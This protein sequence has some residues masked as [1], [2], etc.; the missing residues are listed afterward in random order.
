MSGNNANYGSSNGKTVFSMG[1]GADDTRGDMEVITANEE[2]RPGT[3]KVESGPTDVGVPHAD[4]L[5]TG[6]VAA[7]DGEEEQVLVSHAEAN[8]RIATRHQSYSGSTRREESDFLPDR[9]LAYDERW[10]ESRLRPFGVTLEQFERMVSTVATDAGTE[11]ETFEERVNARRRVL[12]ESERYPRGAHRSAAAAEA[13]S[14]ADDAQ[15]AWSEDEAAALEAA[16]EEADE[17]EPVVL[18]DD[19]DDEETIA[20][21]TAVVGKQETM[22]RLAN[23][24]QMRERADSGFEHAPWWN[25]CFDALNA[26]SADEQAAFEAAGEQLYERWEDEWT[27]VLGFE[28]SPVGLAALLADEADDEQSARD[29]AFE[30]MQELTREGN[31]RIIGGY[32][33]W[34]TDA[35]YDKKLTFEGEVVA[36]FENPSHNRQAQAGYVVDDMG[37]SAKFTIWKGH[38]EDNSPDWAFHGACDAP[39]RCRTVSKGDRVLFENFTA[40]TFNGEVVIESTRLGARKSETHILSE[41]EGPCPTGYPDVEGSVEAPPERSLSIDEDDGPKREV[42]S[43]THSVRSPG[44][45]EQQ[46]PDNLAY[47]VDSDRFK[48]F[49]EKIAFHKAMEWTFPARM[50]PDWFIEANELHTR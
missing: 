41:G 36:V 49:A 21:R 1:V 38:D 26:L 35:K 2:I 50:C 27:E 28:P 12:S 7:N 13:D 25:G 33:L 40:R 42:P 20:N 34:V 24:Y 8:K 4:R 29:V 43:Q 22:S 45:V 3:S 46:M 48:G 10:G 14:P 15:Y 11:P 30:F 6:A 31:G 32:E 37:R 44:W 47:R 23:E 19:G 16:L 39:D 9:E 18:D 17:S 5:I